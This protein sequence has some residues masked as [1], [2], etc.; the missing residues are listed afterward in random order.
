MRQTRQASTATMEDPLARAERFAREADRRVAEQATRVAR[1][2]RDGHWRQVGRAKELLV[3][4]EGACQAA[5]YYLD[6]VRA[7]Y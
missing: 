5:H 6:R 4:F 3:I 7:Q 1:L 2:E